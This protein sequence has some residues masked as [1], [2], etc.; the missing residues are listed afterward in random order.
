M[1][2]CFEFGMINGNYYSVSS[3]FN[4]DYKDLIDNALQKK[5]NLYNSYYGHYDR[6]SKT[7][8]SYTF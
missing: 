2:C 6:T 7:N 5:T 4:K 1:L 3:E 8:K